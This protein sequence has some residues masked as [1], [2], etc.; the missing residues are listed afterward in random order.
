MKNSIVTKKNKEMKKQQKG[1]QKF[2]RI[3]L[4]LLSFMFPY[5]WFPRYFMAAMLDD[6]N[7][8]SLTRSF[9]KCHPAFLHFTIIKWVS[10]DWSQTIYTDIVSIS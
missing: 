8:R 2:E 10:R 9:S 1:K 3:S 4:F 6:T 7:N 5:R